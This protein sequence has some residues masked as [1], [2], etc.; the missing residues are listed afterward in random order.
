MELKRTSISL[1]AITAIFAL[2]TPT[3]A[4]QNQSPERERKLEDMVQKLLDKVDGLEKRI[5]QLESSKSSPSIG[6]ASRTTAPPS[7]NSSKWSDASTL[8]ERRAKARLQ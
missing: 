7:L 3:W 6:S 1:L 8:L 4:Q 5:H 2:S